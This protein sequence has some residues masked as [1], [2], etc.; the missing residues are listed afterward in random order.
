MREIA[1]TGPL[2]ITAAHEKVI[3]AILMETL[4]PGDHVRTGAAIGVDAFVARVAY[5]LGCR[6]HTVVPA[7]RSRV[8]PEWRFFCHTSEELPP[9]REPYRARNVVMVA[10][11]TELIGFPLKPEKDPSQ[12]RS[13]T[14]MTVRIAQRAN[15]PVQ[16]YILSELAH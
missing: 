16:I 14:W 8:D 3:E 2:Y 9:S 5:R 4:R 12:L 15:K 11:A 7:N 10:P 6:V 13:G 1:F